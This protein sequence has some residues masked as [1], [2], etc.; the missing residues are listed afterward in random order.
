MLVAVL[1]AACGSP[2]GNQAAGD[3]LAATLARE[4]LDRLMA[5]LRS[6]APWAN[7][8][9]T[10]T[11]INIYTRTPN[12]LESLRV[13]RRELAYIRLCSDEARDMD[14]E[15]NVRPIPEE[16]YRSSVRALGLDPDS[17]HCPPGTDRPVAPRQA[18]QGQRQS[19]RFAHPSESFDAVLSGSQTVYATLMPAYCEGLLQLPDPATPI[20]PIRRKWE[21][22]IRFETPRD[23]VLREELGRAIADARLRGAVRGLVIRMVDRNPNVAVRGLAEAET[24]WDSDPSNGTCGPQYFGRCGSTRF[25]K[26]DELAGQITGGRRSYLRDASDFAAT[27]TGSPVFGFTLSDAAGRIDGAACLLADGATDSPGPHGPE[28]SRE[29]KRALA[30][31]C[32]AQVLGLG[33]PPTSIR[34]HAPHAQWMFATVNPQGAIIWSQT[35]LQLITHLYSQP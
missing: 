3:E 17:I 25:R 34:L 9:L 19:R 6:A 31:D 28:F 15:A 27:D 11:E 32:V 29:A 33:G 35:A 24:C 22:E 2:Q 16:R 23:P 13:E 26:Y 1:L 12:V 8:R 14:Q 20:P 4:S 30:I 10:A 7:R 18:P 21:S 5:Q